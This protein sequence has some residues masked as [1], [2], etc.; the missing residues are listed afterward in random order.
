MSLNVPSEG[1]IDV[2]TMLAMRVLDLG[3]GEGREVS[4]LGLSET[5]QII[6]LDVRPVKHLKAHYPSRTFVQARAEEIPFTDLSF[7]CVVCLIALPYM[8]IPKALAEAHRVLRPDGEIRLTLHRFRYTLHELFRV[9]F[10]RPKAMLF[11]TWVMMNGFIFHVTGKPVSVGGKHETFQTKRGITIALRRAGFR[12]IKFSS[13]QGP[14][15]PRLS[16]SAT[17]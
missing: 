14:K 9:A 12:N 2:L 4:H 16:V 11:R 1:G 15:G 10:P 13:P 6:G 3:C 7:D 17:R 8:D 5:D